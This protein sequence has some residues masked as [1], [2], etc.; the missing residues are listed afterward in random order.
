[1]NEIR[2]HKN[3]FIVITNAEKIFSNIVKIGIFPI[4]YTGNYW[5]FRIEGNYSVLRKIMQCG[6]NWEIKLFQSNI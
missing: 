5:I 2:L 4:K 6:N 3:A 1:M